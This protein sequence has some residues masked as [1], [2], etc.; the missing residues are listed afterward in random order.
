[1]YNTP[2]SMLIDRERWI[3]KSLF[4]DKLERWECV[5]NLL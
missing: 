4:A 2:F 3:K 1:M 5:I